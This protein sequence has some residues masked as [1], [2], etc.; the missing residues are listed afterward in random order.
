MKISTIALIAIC[1]LSATALSITP[2]KQF[3]EFEPRVGDFKSWALA[4]G[5][6]FVDGITADIVNG[7]APACKTEI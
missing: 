5:N 6:G 4:F 7:T 2:K 1:V 3:P